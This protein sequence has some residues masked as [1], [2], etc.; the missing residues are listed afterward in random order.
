MAIDKTLPKWNAPEVTKEEVE[1]ANILTVDLALY[2]NDKAGLVKTVETALSRDGFFY[3]VNHG[4]SS[5]T[6][7]IYKTLLLLFRPN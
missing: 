6:V 7:S 2:D 5:E 4:I 3:V 1:W